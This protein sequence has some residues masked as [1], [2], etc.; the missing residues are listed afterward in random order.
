LDDIVDDESAAASGGVEQQLRRVSQ[1]VGNDNV[2]LAELRL[3][4]A[5]ATVDTAPTM[6]QRMFAD[7]L[8]HYARLVA[9]FPMDY[10]RVLS[11]VVWTSMR[12]AYRSNAQLNDTSVRQLREVYA[13]GRQLYGD[14]HAKQMLDMRFGDIHLYENWQKFCEK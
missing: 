3:R 7:A 11:E 12:I 8:A 13:L 14:E 4:A 6:S 10:E 5:R 2:R 9:Y 1:L